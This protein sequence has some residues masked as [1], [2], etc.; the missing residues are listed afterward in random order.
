MKGSGLDPE[1]VLRR[2]LKVISPHTQAKVE[3]CFRFSGRVVLADR[4]MFDMLFVYQKVDF[5]TKMSDSSI[6]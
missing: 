4:L 2:V 6:L 5:L 1:E 3:G